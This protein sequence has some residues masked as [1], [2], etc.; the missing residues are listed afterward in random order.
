MIAMGYCHHCGGPVTIIASIEDPGV[1]AKVL[2]HLGLPTRARP[3]HR[4]GHAISFRRPDPTRG[5]NQSGSLPD[6]P[7]LLGL[8]QP[9]TP[10]WVQILGN[11]LGTRTG[12][13]LL[14]GCT[15]HFESDDWRV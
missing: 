5:P 10:P 1:I 9:Q 3:V 13:A 8:P 7:I 15:P 4:R 11:I 12:K 14:A 2:A 6:P